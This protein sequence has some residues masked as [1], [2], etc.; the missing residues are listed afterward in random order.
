MQN[1]NPYIKAK[2]T[3]RTKTQGY[4]VNIKEQEQSAVKGN[5]M[6]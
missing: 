2:N 4:S 5:D 1:A 3:K 6:Q